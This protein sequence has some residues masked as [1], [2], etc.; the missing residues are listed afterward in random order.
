MGP[1]GADV[2]IDRPF[3]PGLIFH[4]QEHHMVIQGTSYM[5]QS[6]A[7]SQLNSTNVTLPSQEIDSR[8]SE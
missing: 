7:K 4:L 1:Q 8:S 5:Q 2:S 6:V 3:G